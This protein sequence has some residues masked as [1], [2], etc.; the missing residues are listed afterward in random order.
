MSLEKKKEG[1]K[2]SW[3]LSFFQFLGFGQVDGVFV[4]V[5][6]I[7]KTYDF[8]PQDGIEKGI[9]VKAKKEQVL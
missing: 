4:D 7:V 1:A 3:S 5:S 9:E 2:D 8:L 6:V